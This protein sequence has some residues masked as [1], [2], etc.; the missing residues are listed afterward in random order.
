MDE[1][2]LPGDLSDFLERTALA[3]GALILRH[4]TEGVE[5]RHKA[6]CSPVTLADEEAEALICRDLERHYPDIP[7]VAEE[8]VAAGIVPP[9]L[10]RRFF[11]VDPL[12]GTREFVAGRA[13]F[14][15]NIALV[16][17]GSPLAG[18]VHAPALGMLYATDRDGAYRLNGGHRRERLGCRDRPALPV[19]VISRSHNTPETDAYLASHGI[20]AFAAIGSSLKFC[21]LA[22]GKA[23]IYPRMSRTMEWDT[24]AGD[25]VLRAA[26]GR[27]VTLAGDA[28]AYGKTGQAGDSDFANPHF[29]ASA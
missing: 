9:A 14:T 13:E 17:D 21:L 5:T 10:G 18:V 22:E 11:L 25:A 8:R 12:D 29:I 6:D 2:P 7:I 28:L 1:L 23:D 15:V 16:V 3:A 20:T 4:F 27:T 26:G 19:A 24:A